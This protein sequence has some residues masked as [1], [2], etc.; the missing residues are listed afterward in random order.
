M[1]DSTTFNV[2]VVPFERLSIDGTHLL[3]LS[4]NSTCSLMVRS[5]AA[6]ESNGKSLLRALT[7]RR[8]GIV[9]FIIPSGGSRDHSM[10]P[11]GGFA[12][13]NQILFVDD[14]QHLLDSFRR[15]LHSEFTIETAPGGKEGLAAIHLFGPFPVV[16][17]DMQMPGLSGAEFLAR[18]RELSPHTVRM[19]LTG[20]K[21]LNHAI[22]AVNEGQ[23]F[24]Y[25]TKPCSRE[26][27]VSAIRLAL[28]QYR[29]N[30]EAGELIKEAREHRLNAAGQNSHELLP[31]K[32]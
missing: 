31:A 1:W 13:T 14:D 8:D 25:L 15:N 6:D 17:S 23:I 16:I 28:A 27:M 12:L 21:D 10:R 32:E 11:D 29:A 22:A 4:R 9:G 3:P 26:E 30:V 19:L 20:H 18:V 24:R 7:A 2:P 5:N